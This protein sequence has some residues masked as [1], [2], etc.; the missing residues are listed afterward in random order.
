MTKKVDAVFEGGGVKGI[1]LV[2]AVA[3]IEENGYTFENLA[4]TSAGAIV[5]ALLAAGYTASEVKDIIESLDFDQL[6][7][8]SWLD[9]IPLVGKL[10]SLLLEKGIYE[11]TFFEELLQKYLADKGVHTF[12]D[13]IME[14]YQ[15]NPQYRYKLQVIASDISIG[16]ML[17]L[18][19]DAHYLGINPD[20]MS[21]ALAVRM[22]MSIPYFFEPVKRSD[23]SGI[24]HYVVD[25]GLLSNYPI[26]LFDDG[27]AHPAWPTF[28]FNLVDPNPNQPHDIKGPL[29]MLKALFSTMM[30]AH[31]TRY[32]ESQNFVRTIPIPTAGVQ[33]TDFNLSVQQKTALYE[34]GQTAAK[35]FLATWDFEK[36]KQEFRAKPLPPRIQEIWTAAEEL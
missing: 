16:K 5:A 8:E 36:Y 6:T 28:G 9:K 34:S 33:A 12:K 18:P 1:G 10:A 23:T 21:V 32:I 20:D 4:G 27:T 17:V 13:L 22:S 19:R 11:G 25:G 15:D 2:G 29:S 26:W 30:E 24:T 35:E 14:D 31:D 3:V 7:D